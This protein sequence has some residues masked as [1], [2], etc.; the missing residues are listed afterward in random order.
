MR[1][2]W[3][4]RYVRSL[5]V[6]HDGIWLATYCISNVMIWNCK[7]GGNQ[8]LLHHGGECVKR[9]RISKDQKYLLSVTSVP[10]IRV[11]RWK[12]G[13]LLQTI[14][15]HTPVYYLQITPTQQIIVGPSFADTRT[16]CMD[17]T[18]DLQ[19]S[20]VGMR[21]GEIYL[22]NNAT[23]RAMIWRAHTH[24]V[25]A[26]KIS[27]PLGVIVSSAAYENPRLWSCVDGSFQGELVGHRTHVRTL[28]ISEDGLWVITGGMDC[29][30]R[31]W[32]LT[33][34]TC[35]SV[36]THPSMGGVVGITISGDKSTIVASCRRRGIHVWR[37][38][39][40]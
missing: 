29:T 32:D 4:F 33:L 26:V 35:F 10:M 38:Q 31:L 12:T 14:R 37:K 24:E 28:C 25:T 16:R 15:I 21:T 6:D 40:T 22:W 18:D 13:E 34:G 1:D 39:N 36:L 3:H 27:A 23:K 30:V 8:I 9:I 20:V 11:W 5:A 2:T 19:C 7:T 17:L